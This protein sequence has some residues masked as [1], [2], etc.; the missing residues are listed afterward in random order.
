MFSVQLH[1]H[2]KF[3]VRFLSFELALATNKRTGLKFHSCALLG[4]RV[5]LVISLHY[6]IA[7]CKW[8]F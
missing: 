1:L 5:S 8:A 2:I 4:S 3:R 7:M 6:K